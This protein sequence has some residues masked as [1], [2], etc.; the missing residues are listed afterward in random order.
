MK[1]Y[2]LKNYEK[3]VNESKKYKITILKIYSESCKI[4]YLTN[5]VRTVKI[6]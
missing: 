6:N 3:K 2:I 5:E 4:K 1:I